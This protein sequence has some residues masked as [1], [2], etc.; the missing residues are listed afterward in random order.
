MERKI[1]NEVKDLLERY[2]E[3]KLQGEDL[4]LIDSN[5]LR[6]CSHISNVYNNVV[7]EPM[8]A[9]LTDT[10]EELELALAEE[11]D[12]DTD[13]FELAIT[14]ETDAELAETDEADASD[15][16]T[17]TID[18]KAAL[19]EDEA[20]PAELA[21]ELVELETTWIRQHEKNEEQKKFVEAEL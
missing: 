11:S 17:D 7:G 18:C 12:D 2:E 3:A 19:A 21:A 13:A 5:I 1:V 20:N 9:I 15:A 14:E 16:D 6:W 10:E 4:Y 8:D